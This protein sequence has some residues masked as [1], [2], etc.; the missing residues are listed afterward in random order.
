MQDST[1]ART[2]PAIRR[3]DRACLTGVALRRAPW[4][5]ACDG[6]G[7]TVVEDRPSW[8][9]VGDTGE[10]FYSAETREDYCSCRVGQARQEREEHGA[11]AVAGGQVM[12]LFIGD[13]D[14]DFPF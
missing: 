8:T 12:A 13:A 14:A 5:D 1:H 7:L 3:I 6:S 10:G 4:C 9:P 2:Y 11:L